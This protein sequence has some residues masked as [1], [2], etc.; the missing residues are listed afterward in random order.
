[1]KPLWSYRYPPLVAVVGVLVLIVASCTSEPEVATTTTAPL[2]T[3]T[4]AAPRSTTSTSTQ[5]LHQPAVGGEVIIATESEPQTLNSFMAGGDLFSVGLLGQAYAAGVYDIDAT[6]LSLIPELVTELPTK[7]N[8]GVVVND[9]GTMTV[10]YK[11]RDEARWEDGVP[12]SGA[13]FQFTL[14]T[15]LNPD[16]PIIKKDYEDVVG[17]AA[18]A[19]TFEFTLARPTLRYETMFGEIIPKHSVEGTDFVVDWNDKRWASAGPFIFEQ[20]TKGESITLRRNPNYWKVDSK[21]E[22]QLPYLESVTYLFERD[23]PAMIEAFKARDIDVFSPKATVQN[24]QALRALESQGALVE[25]LPGPVWEHLN[26]QFGPGRLD[27]NETSCNDVYEMRLAIAQSVDRNAITEDVLGG[28]I[29]P[30]QSHVD[31]YSP[32]ISQEAWS[33]Y[34]LD[35]DA[36]ARNHATA[37]EIAGM[38]CSVTFTANTENDER[39]RLSELLADMF[40]ASGIEY[41]SQLED[42]TFFFVETLS[43]GLW[44]VGQWTW[45]GSPGFASLVGF[46]DVLDP[47]APPP[48]GTNFYRWGTADSSVID[49]STQRFAELRDLMQ[50]TIDV[51]ELTSLIQE[52]ENILADDLVIIPL[53]GHPLAAAV[54]ED[55]IVGF[56]HNPTH[57]GFTWNIETWRRND[58]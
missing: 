58:L 13:D 8:G 22:Q 26:F 55:E 6:S 57:A 7:E 48:E 44:D 28:M 38:E 37:V 53:Y 24:V 40:A 31:A 42:S 51:D 54:W 52:A 2:Q 34:S 23:E 5:Q 33:Q 36:A 3:T 32:A 45:R 47:E 27:M 25:T 10:R 15:I 4:T 17:S 14:D 16:Y 35:A 41:R 56:K 39:V 11:I 21:T 20:W 50:D 9:D 18:G 1:V 19:K 30:L 46:H 49:D 29:G 12:I 43:T